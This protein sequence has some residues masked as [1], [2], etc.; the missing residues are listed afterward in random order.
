MK[1]ALLFFGQG[2]QVV[3]MG[4]D[5]AA[6][7]PTAAALFAKADEI[8]GYS[9][10]QTA[11]EG[12]VE[13]LTKTSVAQPALYTHGLA[14]LTLLREKFPAIPC[15]GSLALRCQTEAH[16]PLPIIPL[17]KSPQLNCLTVPAKAMPTVQAG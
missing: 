15:T 13:E 10:S 17:V 12:P 3:G 2:A 7:Y 8:L 5:L 16:K 9:L 11:F 4:K 1:T 6:N 14:L